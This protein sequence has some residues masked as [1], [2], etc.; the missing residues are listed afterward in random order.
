M[1]FQRVCIPLYL[2][3]LFFI[4]LGYLAILPPFEGF[5][6][7]A[8]YSSIRQIA[9]TKTIPLYGSSFL[10]REVTDYK[11]PVAYGSLEPPFDRGMVYS[12]F[13]ARPDLVES[14]RRTYRQSST[15]S[16]YHPS[17]VQNWEAQHP[18][19][20]YIV[21][22]PLEKI[23]EH[24]SFV[25]RI[26][27]LRLASYFLA[28]AGVTL[29]L[30]AV[31]QSSTSLKFDPSVIGF[32]LYPIVLPMFFP[33]FTRIGNDCLCLFLVGATAFFLS[34]R[35]RDEN[36]KKLSSAIGIV[37]GLGLL[38]KAFFLPIVAA[39]G[40]FLLVRIF[41]DGRRSTTRSAHWQN[42]LLIFLP[43]FLIGGGWYVYEFV[44]F[45]SP[46]GSSDSIHLA[47]QGG[48]I[49]NLRQNF[50]LYAVIRGLV[51]TAVSYSWA[52]TW[53]LARLPVP[54]QIPLL[55]LAAW[56]FGAFALQLKRRPLID[57][58][59]LPVLLFGAFGAGFL[60]HVIMSVASNGNGNTPGWYIHILMPWVAPVLGIGVCLLLRN[61]RTK[62][63]LLGLLSYAVLFQIMALWAQFALFTGCATKSDDKYYVFSG[64]YFCLDQTPLLM[65]RLAVL[66]WPV[67]AAVGFGGGLFCALL[68]IAL[69]SGETA[70]SG[71]YETDDERFSRQ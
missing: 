30:V 44:A 68:L 63:F 65:D 27:L 16:F 31:K 70:A 58:A 5:D 29:G 15:P 64:H 42:F 48:L 49:A 20:Y 2:L 62:S 61:R 38:T 67:L 24:F 59:W 37:L 56:C 21:L 55:V 11:G 69:W 34:K 6:E 36:N 7:I 45:G 9:D 54:L 1:F 71:F 40:V 41:Q 17:P 51:V 52:G 32:M 53:S 46:I 50:S 14:Y 4:G 3:A 26:L 57:P 39:L 22:A 60:Y 19:L 47:H 13:F 18:P 10:D 25:T 12:K 35:F 66:G 8:H 28:L 23:T 43:A 33:E